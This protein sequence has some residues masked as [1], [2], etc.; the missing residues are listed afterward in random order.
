[1][2]RKVYKSDVGINYVYVHMGLPKPTVSLVKPFV[3]AMVVN[4][5]V[6]GSPCSSTDK[7]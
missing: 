3:I 2:E 5:L 1:M 4:N 7:K 6:V